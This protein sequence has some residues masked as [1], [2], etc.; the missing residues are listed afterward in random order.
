MSSN[1]VTPHASR[2]LNNSAPASPMTQTRA[3]IF[4]VT[5]PL[6]PPELSAKGPHNVHSSDS[7]GDQ[8]SLKLKTMTGKI[9]DVRVAT[10]ARVCDVMD[11]VES[12]EGVP[13]PF[14]QLSLRG[15]VLGGASSYRFSFS[16]VM[17]FATS[18]SNTTP[19]QLCN[20]TLTLLAPFRPHT[21]VDE[22]LSAIDF[23]GG[24]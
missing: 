20:A 16:D 2:S 22:P 9:V 11:V 13:A 24:T 1:R 21:T 10:H 17:M 18:V 15:R 7:K 5:S 12:L 4:P 3:L 23:S 19:P 8:L 6:T 14:Q